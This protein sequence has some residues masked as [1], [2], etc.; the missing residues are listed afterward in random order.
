MTANFISLRTINGKPKAS[1]RNSCGLTVTEY[2]IWTY[3]F[4]STQAI[5]YIALEFYPMMRSL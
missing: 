2:V 5:I 1:S 3:C 4:T